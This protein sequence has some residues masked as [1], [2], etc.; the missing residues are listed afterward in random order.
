V[1][2]IRGERLVFGKADYHPLDAMPSTER[3]DAIVLAVP[4]RR[5]FAGRLIKVVVSLVLIAVIAVGSLFL[6]LEGGYL[7]RTLA[8]EAETA[9]SNTLGDGFEPK[10]GAIRLRFSQ[11]WMLA[12]EAGDVTIK[13]RE[14]GVTALKADSI[15]AVLDPIA[16]LYGRI[17]LARTEIGSAEGDLR[18]L[19]PQPQIDWSKVRVDGLPA[20]LAIVYPML[21][22]AIAMLKKTNTEELIAGKLSLLL[23]TPTEM[24]DSVELDDVD[25]SSPED[26]QYQLTAML[27]HGKLAPKLT[28]ALQSDGG[29][30]TGFQASIENLASEPLMMKYSKVTGEKRYGVDLPLELAVASERDRSLVARVIAGKGTFYADG[31]AQPVNAG[32]AIL[33]YDFK[34]NKI[35][36][37]DGLMDFGD[38]VV[39]L[40][41]ALLDLDHVAKDKPHGFAFEIVGNDAVASAEGSNEAPEHFNA[42]TSGYFLPETSELRLDTI[43]IA[44][45]SGNFAGSLDVH[46]VK[47]SP[48]V[49]FA[50]RSDTLS[51]ATVKQLWPFWFGKKARHW[52]LANIT[53]GTVKNGEIDVSLAAGRIPEHP[54][55]LVFKDNELR[56]AFDVENTKVKFLPEMPQSDKTSGHFEMKDRNIRIDIKDGVVPLPSGKLLQAS[57]GV[58][59]IEDIS[60]KPIMASLAITAAGDAAAAAEFSGFKPIDA[61]SRMPFVPGDL[62]GSVKADISADF[63]LDKEHNP[64]KPTWDVT[65]G[66]HNVGFKQ[67]LKGRKIANIDGTVAIDTQS[68][69]M[70]GT[71]DIDGMSFDVALT[72][73]FRKGPDSERKWRIKGDVS[74]RELLKV[75]PTLAGYVA[76]NIGIDIESDDGS[77]QKAKLALTNTEISVPI[78]GWR[79]GPGIAATAEFIIDKQDNQ[80]T[81]RDLEFSGDGF[82]AK[83]SMVLDSK[84]VVSAKFSKVKLSSA[85]DFGLTLQRKS[86]GL[87]INVSGNS[88]DLRPF[89]S[90]VK[91]PSGDPGAPTT[92]SNHTVT[93]T[94]DNAVGYNKETLSAIDLKL[95]TIKGAVSSLQFS[96][97]TRSG[98]AV[99]ITRDTT[100][101]ALEI[102]SGDAGAAARFADIYRNMNGGLLN[103]SLKARDKDSWRGSVDLRNFAL[104]NE[105]RLKS[106]VSARTGKDGRS[107]SEAVKADIDVSSQK[108]RRGFARLMIDGKLVRIDNGVVRGDEVGATFQG[109]VRDQ[110]G[111]MDMTGTFMPAYG[112]N[113]LFSELPLIGAILGNGRD[114]GLL[115]ITFKLV[116]AFDQP[117]LSINPLS[118]IAPGV[119]RNIFEF[120]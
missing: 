34:A 10:V 17:A 70:K 89:L 67:A 54:E 98:Q 33:S 56:I 117:K 90:Q 27:L 14:S 96:A 63:S 107:L 44:A 116:G 52:I 19:P 42:T 18:F 118:L 103:V 80:T 30:A 45:A 3:G 72:E 65:L 79:K 95:Q 36:L 75:A 8:A 38:T 100:A 101:G 74:E 73:P 83:G 46:F 5:S 21:D 31:E 13:H 93:A 58:F 84:G 60:H 40:E 23:P 109:T 41:G 9:L 25:F 51:V 88:I 37:S 49:N 108:F 15:K 94:V 119:F 53:G 20:A 77:L 26:N 97:V 82:G 24:G 68:A 28:V 39:P 7:D 104:V 16:L 106:I 6:G 112:L 29:R 1:N 43:G 81:I 61:L 47:P 66:L 86:S 114:R 115:G 85:D 110:N 113:R 48:A 32:R 111:N 12:F 64:P 76:G 69:V 35:E 120:E 57:N 87:A 22:Q 99:V 92:R 55:P 62:T 2:E 4:K 11:N 105:A 78:F 50:A 59:Q 102:S 91:S 71:A